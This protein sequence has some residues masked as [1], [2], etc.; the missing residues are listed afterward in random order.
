MADDGRP[1]AGR[2][3]DEDAAYLRHA[4]F[5]ALPRRVRPADVVET[6]ATDTPHPAPRRPFDP[7]D[8]A[9]GRIYGRTT[10]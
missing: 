10:A 9:A 7:H 4:R 1:R 6:V 8:P 2:L 3:T 5:G